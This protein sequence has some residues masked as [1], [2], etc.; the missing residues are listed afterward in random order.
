V[1][2]FCEREPPAEILSVVC[3]G[4]SVRR[5]GSCI[6][7]RRPIPAYRFRHGG[8]QKHVLTMF[9]CTCYICKVPRVH[10]GLLYAARFL[11]VCVR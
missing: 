8:M 9:E 2:V 6:S 10:P 11:R 5:S 4:S 3:E 7:H 1:S